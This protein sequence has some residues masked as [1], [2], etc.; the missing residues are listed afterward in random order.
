MGNP[1]DDL[2][3]RECEKIA[4]IKLTTGKSWS[5]SLNS[6]ED[7]AADVLARVRT[8]EERELNRIVEVVGKRRDALS[9]ASEPSE[10]VGICK[11]ILAFGGAGIGLTVAFSDKLKTADEKTVKIVLIL[12]TFYFELILAS[13]LV[14][15][16]QTRFLY[17]FVY[18]K[19]I[20]NTR[21]W[22][23]TAAVGDVARWP[24]QSARSRFKYRRF[25]EWI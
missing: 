25:Y 11:Q 6:I 16:L 20:G 18:L 10:A 13:L 7:L 12:G 14:Y 23:Y 24:I 3:D 2:V 21:P 22:F 1:I 5:D 19:K 17:P 9:Q 15:L 8:A 4:A